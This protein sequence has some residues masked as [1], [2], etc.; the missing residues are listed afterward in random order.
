[1]GHCQGLAH[2]AVIREHIVAAGGRTGRSR[3]PSLFALTSG[4]NLGHGTGREV[5]RHYTHLAERM[6]GIARNADVSFS[7]LMDLFNKSTTGA[8][9]KEELVA[10]AVALGAR[11]LEDPNRGPTVVRTLSGSSFERSQWIL[12]RSRPEVGFASAEVTLPWLA[13]A[14]AGIN[15]AGV[16]VAIAPRSASYGGGVNAGAVNHRNAPHAIL[17]VQ[18]C[19]QRFE[20]L[21][22]CLDWCRKRPCSGNASLIVADAAGRIARIEVEG[23]DCTVTDL[24]ADLTLDGAPPEVDEELRSHFRDHRQI[25]LAALS[26]IGEEHDQLSVWLEP[27]RRSLSIRP[28]G[29]AASEGKAIEIAV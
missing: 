20:D 19:L 23:V 15:Q 21:D 7:A 1:M 16:A 29:D 25:N 8:A 13:T 17:L 18:E 9:P 26:A 24:D 12:R 6:V 14:I 3:W 2:R 10:E 27:A 5:I 11:R 28:V 4:S 22:G